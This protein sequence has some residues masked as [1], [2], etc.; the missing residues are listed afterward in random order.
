MYLERIINHFKI[1]K[2]IGNL[3]IEDQIG[4]QL[5]K[6]TL[7]ASTMEKRII[8]NL[9]AKLNQRVKQE[10]EQIIGIFDS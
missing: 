10:T 4:S 5:I 7:N 8:L 1:M 2:E 9:N 6:G 3:L